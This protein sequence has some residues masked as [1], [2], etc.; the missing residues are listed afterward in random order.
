MCGLFYWVFGWLC[1]CTQGMCTVCCDA[2]QKANI[3][4]EKA[5]FEQG[6]CCWADDGAEFEPL[7]SA[8]GVFPSLSIGGAALAVPFDTRDNW[9]DLPYVCVK[10]TTRVTLF[11][12]LLVLFRCARYLF[13]SPTEYIILSRV[14]D[15]RDLTSWHRRIAQRRKE[16]ITPVWLIFF[17]FFHF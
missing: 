17:F 14:I 3:R 16:P 8:C 4:V 15:T 1:V 9:H 10:N 5:K 11:S 6:F 7:T 12:C 2:T 13:L